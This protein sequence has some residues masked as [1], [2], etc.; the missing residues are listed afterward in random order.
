MLEF[1]Q[2]FYTIFSSLILFLALPNELNY[3]GSPLLGFLA[4]VPLYIVYTNLKSYRQ[5]FFLFFL[6]G[7]LTHFLSSFWLAN[8]KNFAALTLGASAIG[9]AFIEGAMGFLFYLSISRTKNKLVLY[10]SQKGAILN[11]VKILAF[12]ILYTSWEWIKSIGFLGY[13]WATLSSTMYKAKYF[14]QIAD[15]TGTYGIGFLT[16]FF[17]ALLGELIILFYNLKISIN[18]KNIIFSYFNAFLLFIS[19]F[20][21]T[22]VYGLYNY[23]KKRTPIKVLNTVMVQQNADPWKTDSDSETILL[24]EQITE[25]KIK[26][27]RENGIDTNLVVWCEGA[28]KYNF[29]QA[30]GYYKNSPDEKPLIPF[31]QETKIPFM[32]GGSY[33]K[34]QE[35]E[36]K[37]YNSTLLF[38]SQGFYRG[39]YGKIHLVPIAE[40]IPFG[41]VKFVK[42]FLKKVLRISAGW[43]P[44]NQYVYFEIQGDF[45]KERFVPAV[46][47]VSLKISKNEQDKI[48]NERPFVKISTPIC[49]DDAFPD[50]MTPLAKNGTEIFINL[51]DD[52]WS[53]KK[54]AEYQHFVVSHY[55]SIE[56][57]TTLA[58]TCNSGY[59]VV[60]DPAGK[61]LK[62]MPL[63][64]AGGFYYQIPVYSRISTIYMRFGNWLPA[65]C[66]ILFIAYSIFC[67]IDLKKP[68]IK[69]ERKIKSKKNKKS[70]R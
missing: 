44:G 48:E 33:V 6:H 66:S 31:I 47:T 38:D 56:T 19:L 37:N 45:P 14:T 25:E 54:S 59:S 57:R 40:A 39:Q 68:I 27:A 8:F 18:K 49:Y 2:I 32:L 70:K 1:F 7:G 42:N 64:T 50:V 23:H 52:S 26:E 67:F 24:S 5:A 60:I 17:S 58:R 55:R 12:P 63:F 16:A 22:S 69:S 20:F 65:L 30:Y 41:E 62:D 53:Q 3:F 10:S 35:R 43:T 4:L 46:K 51:T 28:L 13:P 29:P 11:L 9:T 36:R 61:V 34:Y 15:I 21:L